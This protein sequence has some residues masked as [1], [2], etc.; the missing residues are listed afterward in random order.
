LNKET[1]DDWI[2]NVFKEKKKDPLKEAKEYEKKGEESF[3]KINN[4]EKKFSQ[5]EAISFLENDKRFRFLDEEVIERTSKSDSKYDL[6]TSKLNNLG[7]HDKKRPYAELDVSKA[8]AEWAEDFAKACDEFV[9]KHFSPS[10]YE[11]AYAAIF[12][13]FFD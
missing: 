8:Y 5:D 6:A 3:S 1:K 11:K 9:R 7:K 10:E 13:G 2:E 12:W 4:A